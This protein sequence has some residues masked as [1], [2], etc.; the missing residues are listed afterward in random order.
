M[1]AHH[2]TRP[3][4]CSTWGAEKTITAKCACFLSFIFEREK[5]VGEEMEIAILRLNTKDKMREE[6]RNEGEEMAE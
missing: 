6:G 1:C 4:N 3:L 2:A 5:M